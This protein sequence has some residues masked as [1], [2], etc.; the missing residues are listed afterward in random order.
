MAS[1]AVP[2]S[3][4][5]VR[6]PKSTEARLSNGMRVLVARR[7]TI[8]M[9]AA[10]LILEVGSSADPKGK[11]G[12][13]DFTVRLLRRGAKGLEAK[14]IDDA[15]E[16]V[17]GQLSA[18]A[19]ED[20][21]AVHIT[22]P[23]QRLEVMLEVIGR[24]VR[25]PSFPE[26]E[27]SAARARA[28]AHLAN[29]LD[30]PGTLADR[31]FARAVWGQHP[32]GSPVAGVAAQVRTFRRA[33]V[34]GFHRSFF[35]PRLATLVVA[36]A[37]EPE[38]V[39]RAAEKVFLGWRGGAQAAALPPTD[40]QVPY[41]GRVLLLDKPD[42]TQTQIRIGGVGLR[43]GDPRWHAA[44]V[45]NGVFGGSFTSRLMRE[46]RVKRGLSYG[47]SSHFEG[48]R[49]A[50]AIAFTTF[51]AT[52]QTREAIDVALAEAA[53]MAARGATAKELA[54]AQ[55]YLSGIY[56][57]RLE[58]NEAVAATLAA[59]KIFGLGEDWVPRYRERIARVTR[60]EV[61]QMARAFLPVEA[62]AIVLVGNAA[63][64]RKQLK[65]LGPV[66]VRPA[67]EQE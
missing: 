42:Q 64:V 37:I 4:R 8:P 55:A 18:A 16:R 1:A 54:A 21:T 30:D 59:V 15:V 5:P 3:F 48:H 60:R 61:T 34:V 49:S 11:A 27:V 40:Y 29:D 45:M 26:A 20:L 50:G 58:T 57:L 38:E 31:A 25:E 51:T 9:V 47:A 65:G 46:I 53:K 44:T 10:R 35:G 12:L 39:V 22:A 62:P 52:A 41:R 17:G 56:P 67:A 13:S 63:Q 23:A 7:G 6:L 28:L 33:D 32:Y 43:Y 24:L 36:G 2:T 19:D 14:Q 66:D